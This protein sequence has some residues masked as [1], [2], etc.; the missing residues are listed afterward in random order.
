MEVLTLHDSVLLP[1]TRC[2]VRR[3]DRPH[4][5]RLAHDPRAGRRRRGHAPL[6]DAHH[7]PARGGWTHHGG[8]ARRCRPQ[9]HAR[10]QR[11][12]PG[13]DRRLTVQYHRGACRPRQGAGRVRVGGG[14]RAVRRPHAPRSTDGYRRVMDTRTRA[15]LRTIF[16]R[17]LALAAAWTLVYAAAEVG[18]AVADRGSRRGRPTA[19]R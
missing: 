16:W 2:R 4:R 10:L 5:R 8:P 11:G 9:T 15:V 18:I 1:G 19:A 6:A 7:V 13:A 14:Q 17:E 3:R 12:R